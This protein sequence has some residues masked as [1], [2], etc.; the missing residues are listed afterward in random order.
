MLA[1]RTDVGSLTS[2][3]VQN[4]TQTGQI[5]GND[6]LKP[7]DVQ[8]ICKYLKLPLPTPDVSFDDIINK[9]GLTRE[10]IYRR[11]AQSNSVAV[12]IAA[13][14]LRNGVTR[15]ADDRRF[16]PAPMPKGVTEPR[17]PRMTR[18]ELDDVPGEAVIGT[19]GECP[20]KAGSSRAE[21]FAVYKVGKTVAECLA[22]GLRAKDI[23][24]HLADG[25]IS[26]KKE[27]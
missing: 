27:G 13:A 5:T 8:A 18:S 3:P 15:L 24:R 19:V 17:S 10:V 25:I 1:V 7:Q 9:I 11:L 20:S 21:R 26:L 22:E 23:R 16:T 6:A 14:A 4:V 12:M 2:K